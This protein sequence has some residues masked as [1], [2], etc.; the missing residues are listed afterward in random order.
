V[1]LSPERDYRIF[2]DTND[3][4]TRVVF[5]DLN[6]Y[7]SPPPQDNIRKIKVVE[8][9]GGAWGNE[10]LIGSNGHYVA[11][12]TFEFMPKTT[13]PVISG[14]GNTIAYMG[15]TGVEAQPYAIYVSDRSPSGVWSEPAVLP[16]GDM[17]THYGEVSLS[18]DGNTLIHGSHPISWFEDQKTYI[19]TRQA[20]VWG[21][22]VQVYDGLYGFA[23]NVVLSADGNRA[24]FVA[25]YDL[26]LLEKTGGGW[27]AAV[28]VVDTDPATSLMVEYPQF[29][30]DGKSL[31]YWEVYC[32]PISGGCVLTNQNLKRI[33]D[34]GSGWSAPSQVAFS[35]TP[36]WGK[37]G[38]WPAAID[39]TGRRAVFPVVGRLA[40]DIMYSTNLVYTDWRDGAWTEP[41]LITSA[42]DYDYNKQPVLSADGLRLVYSGPFATGFK[43]STILF[44][45]SDSP[46][47][48][49]HTIFLPLVLR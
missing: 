11:D 46:L 7:D 19:S 15:Y 45:T 18:H 33:Y 40:D 5:L 17:T 10:I 14:D 12:S 8:Y 30:A 24:A 22:P 31:F 26:Y 37:D 2:P 43:S 20:G 28:K 47:P 35:D 36:G 38:N 44:S 42:Q 41:V 16:E 49:G 3:N 13:R 48:N 39:A 23:F 25:T 6:Q 34:D 27:G 4:T 32:A 1:D 21:N 9:Q 29:T